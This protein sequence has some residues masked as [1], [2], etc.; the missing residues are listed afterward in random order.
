MYQQELAYK[1]WYAVK[2]PTD[3]RES[4]NHFLYLKPFNFVQTNDWYNIELLMLDCNTWN[5]LTVC[6]QMSS[7][8]FRNKVTNKLFVLTIVT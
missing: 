6:K 7:G 4:F 5:H 1:G 2:Q 8:L 3:Q